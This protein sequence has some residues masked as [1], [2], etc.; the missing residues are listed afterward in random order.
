MNHLAKRLL[1]KTWDYKLKAESMT[2]LAC[3]PW[4][5]GQQPAST[6]LEGLVPPCHSVHILTLKE[7]E[8]VAEPDG[9]END[10]L[11][12]DCCRLLAVAPAWQG[13][14]TFSPG[15]AVPSCVQGSH[16]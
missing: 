5:V 4:M 3:S 12:M 1:C 13:T 16:T 14:A 9:P 10:A 8:V 11:E 2:S 15:M 6:A 7:P